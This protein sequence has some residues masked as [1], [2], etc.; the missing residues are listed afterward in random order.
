MKTIV[1]DMLVGLAVAFAWIGAAGFARLASALDRLHAVAFV[2]VGSGLAIV[3]AAF[4][5]D[6]PSTRAF[7]ILLLW[8]IALVAG[9]AVNQAAARAIF[10]RDEAGE[11]T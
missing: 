10:T 8:L 9:A 7:K 2:T 4:V 6:G 11:R 1:V 5:A 3:A